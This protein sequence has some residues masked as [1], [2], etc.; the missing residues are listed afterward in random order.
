MGFVVFICKIGINVNVAAIAMDI[1]F[2]MEYQSFP[3]YV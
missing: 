2:F 1:I 3:S